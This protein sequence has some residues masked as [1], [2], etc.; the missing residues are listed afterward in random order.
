MDSFNICL[1]RQFLFEGC[2]SQAPISKTE[3]H[4]HDSNSKLALEVRAIIF[5]RHRTLQSSKL[6]STDLIAS[7][8]V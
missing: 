8:L 7:N 6:I 2:Q 3:N 4:R 1:V 5:T